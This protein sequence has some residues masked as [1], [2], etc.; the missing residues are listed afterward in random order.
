MLLFAR[1]VGTLI[2]KNFLVA[3]VRRPISTTFR[4]L[5]L[6][7]IIVLVLSYAQNFLNPPQ[8][9]GVG[10]ANPIKSLEN[11][12]T[13]A[14]SSRNTI[15]FVDSGLTK[16][17]VSTVIQD[18]AKPFHDAGRKVVTI[19]N[20]TAVQDV[21]RTS[22]RGTSNC[23]AAVIIHSSITQPKKGGIWNYT[24]RADP[25]LGGT[26]NVDSQYNDPQVYL[27]PLQKSIDTAIAKYSP[28]GKPEA[29][30]TIDQY[31]WTLET[32]QHR[33]E[34][35][36]N[37]YLVSGIAY[38]G[39]VFFF[40]MVGVVYQLTGLMASEREQGLS[41]LIEAMMPNTSRWQPQAA[42]IFAYHGAFSII[43]F[44]SWLAVGI[45]LSALVF[46]KSNA[47]IIIL[48][49]ITIGL[50]LTSYAIVGASFFKKAQ[51]S[52]I[53]MS[54][55]AVVLAVIPQVLDSTKQTKTTVVALSLIFPSA[56]YTYFLIYLCYWELAPNPTNLNEAAPTSI[57][58]LPPWTVHGTSLWCFLILQIIAYP[59][60]GALIEKI[61][62]GTQ[63]S[64]RSLNLNSA[65][66]GPTVHLGGFSK[67]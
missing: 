11:V 28:N 47:A 6:P 63:S 8:K 52:G 15:V 1:Q 42:R 51:V 29:L 38:F 40:S 23:F 43:Y 55:V 60:L 62:F 2:Y 16:G 64:A 34:S 41:Q 5:I 61:L 67:T 56:N 19:H 26:T 27:L 31:P 66:S 7:L 17:D 24:L 57:D 44:P 20:A 3:A 32:E 58:A 21:C 12:I 36:R 53:T 18:V 39:V 4:A 33:E 35:T 50:A 10:E 65:K 13:K 59:L 45:I 25:L 9:F 14:A 30:A 37:S 22:R 46:T 48:Y 54:V 49:H